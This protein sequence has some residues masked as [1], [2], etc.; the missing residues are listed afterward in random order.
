MP[1]DTGYDALQAASLP[2]GFLGQAVL[3]R[4]QDGQVRW[5]LPL[6]P[7]LQTVPLQDLGLHHQSPPS[8][9][10]PLD[11]GHQIQAGMGPPQLQ[12]AM[13]PPP[14]PSTAAGGHGGGHPSASTAYTLS[15]SGNT[16]KVSR[17]RSSSS[18][19]SSS[20]RKRKKKKQKKG[21]RSRRRSSPKDSDDDRISP[22]FKSLGAPHIHG[23]RNVLPKYQRLRILEC[24]NGEMFSR[25]KTSMLPEQ[26][27][28]MLIF[29]CTNVAPTM[30]LKHL[31][32]K[33]KGQLRM[34]MRN[35]SQRLLTAQ[36]A[37]LQHLSW[38]L[39]S[40]ESIARQLGYQQQWEASIHSPML[41]GFAQSTFHLVGSGTAATQ[42]GGLAAGSGHLGPGQ[43]VMP[44]HA[45]LAPEGAG[46]QVEA[47][48]HAGTH[49]GPSHGSAGGH[50]DMMMALP[51]SSLFPQNPHAP[52]QTV[53]T[54]QGHSAVQ[55]HHGIAMQQH[56]MAA[57]MSHS[58]AQ[59]A[60][61]PAAHGQQLP[62][63]NLKRPQQGQPQVMTPGSSPPTHGMTRGEPS[64]VALGVGFGTPDRPRL[65]EGASTPVARSSGSRSPPIVVE[66][67]QAVAEPG[68]G[69][70]ALQPQGG[71][72]HAGGHLDQHS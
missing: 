54:Q 14:V 36:P 29:I 44:G 45:Q 38:D 26:S 8:Q 12:Q 27:V 69:Q 71:V 55:A 10:P 31:R 51:A 53:G 6:P 20:R 46:M 65:A 28:D 5:H 35:E 58:M 25:V 30:L 70:E 22:A 56:S 1:R 37:R 60:V 16:S 15:E 72:A 23:I 59:A 66:E 9:Q 19:S 4:G 63:G 21:K 40:L 33:K 32:V 11:V 41:Q 64:G 62:V 57:G 2:P 52:M 47:A 68:T 43:H 61:M 42:P 7:Q 17:S 48:M 18:S 39:S 50:A 3:T 13:L 67:S 34:M 49:A 24:I